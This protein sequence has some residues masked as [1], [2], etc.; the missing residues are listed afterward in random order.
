MSKFREEV[1]Y[2]V[3]PKPPSPTAKYEAEWFRIPAIGY[4]RREA[5]FGYVH[6]GDNNEWLDPVPKQLELLEQAK[7]YLKQYSYVK[8]AAWLTAQS[9][10]NI[11][12]N[13]LHLRIKSE[14]DRKRLAAIK[15]RYAR[16]LQLTLAEIEG[17]ETCVAG[18]K[19]RQTDESGSSGKAA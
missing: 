10:R 18:A 15:R 7:D 12:P 5:P 8:V 3:L 1:G 19:A 6:A 13:T 16:E 17:L 11:A 2:W 4:A 14:R 9:G